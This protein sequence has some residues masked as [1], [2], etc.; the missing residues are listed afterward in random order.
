MLCDD[1]ENSFT[2]FISF[3]RCFSV[4]DIFNLYGLTEET[5]EFETEGAQEP[6]KTASPQAVVEKMLIKRASVENAIPEIVYESIAK[7][8][9]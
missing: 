4:S 6:E 1:D 7:T 3:K 2:G 9:Q 5:E 8:E